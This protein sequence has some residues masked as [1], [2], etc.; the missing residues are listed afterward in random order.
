VQACIPVSRNIHAATALVKGLSPQTSLKIVPTV[1]ESAALA[2]LPLTVL[3]LTEE[4]EETF[5]LW[6]I[7]TLGMLA[8]L[9]RTKCSEWP[10]TIEHES[11]G[12]YAWDSDM[13][14]SCEGYLLMLSSNLVEK[15]APFDRRMTLLCVFQ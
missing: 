9:P 4:Q 11:D 15:M 5:S 2:S 8:E 14:R 1:E 13:R 10:C 6:G 12:Q 7:Q 3:D